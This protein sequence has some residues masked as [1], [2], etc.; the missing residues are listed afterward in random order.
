MPE[1]LNRLLDWQVVRFDKHAGE[2]AKRKTKRTFDPIRPQ[3][4]WF[5]E[6]ST[7]LPHLIEALQGSKRD[8]RVTAARI[9]RAIGADAADAAPELA[10]LA[11]GDAGRLRVAARCALAAIA[12]AELCKL[13]ALVQGDGARWDSD[14]FHALRN[15]EERAAPVLPVL[16]AGLESK[17][18]RT[19]RFAIL[20]LESLVRGT[21]GQLRATAKALLAK[22]GER[23]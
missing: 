15:L 18:A 4:Q 1:S 8:D 10:R 3:R 6:T 16:A 7:W 20:V 14:F 11:N 13:D 5:V 17:D 12:P 19:R 9:L 23:R 21:D 22:R 2:P